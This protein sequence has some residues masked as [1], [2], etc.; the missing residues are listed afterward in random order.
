MRQ[1][2]TR[3][4]VNADDFGQS[5]AVNRGVIQ[6]HE[7]GIVTSASLMVRWPGA[8]AAAAYAR[9]HQRLGVGLHMD[10]GEW[11]C[12]EG[13]WYPLYEVVPIADPLA[14]RAEVHRQLDVF[15]ELTGRDP[16]HL[17]SHQHVHR[18]EPAK[19]VINE[20]GEILRVP[21]R[22]YAAGVRYCGDFYGQTEQGTTLPDAI[23]IAALVG[24]FGRLEPGVTEMACHPAIGNVPD[25]M[26]SAERQEEV[27]ALCD[28]RVSRRL[29]ELGI[30]LIDFGGLSGQTMTGVTQ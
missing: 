27:N 24:L 11:G 30:T 17:D 28:R 15:R 12:R 14:L 25:T 19:R 1:A 22:H 3:L 6:A 20:L 16:T 29:Q 4:I 10:L 26:Y 8:A 18:R 23:S 7:Q 2:R 13:E 9:A 21:V 5:E